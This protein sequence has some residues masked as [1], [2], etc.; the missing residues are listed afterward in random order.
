MI[1]YQGS[2]DKIYQYLLIAAFFFL[3]LAVAPNNIAIWLII[4]IWFLSGDYKNKFNQIFQHKLAL[5]SMFFHC[6]A[7]LWTENISWGV[8]ITKKM[9]PFLIVLPV[10]LTITRKENIKYYIGAFLLAIS[11]SETITYLIWFEFIEPFKYAK[12]FSNPTALV[13]HISYNPLLAFAIY[14]VAHKLFL[15][16]NFCNFIKDIT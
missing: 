14:L 13:S 6:I 4:I 12:G 16:K 3:P 11:I 5:A 8:E 9:L 7:L 10:L 15:E 2:V 1:I